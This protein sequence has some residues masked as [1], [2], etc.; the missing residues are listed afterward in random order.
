MRGSVKKKTRQFMGTDRLTGMP[1]LQETPAPVTTKIRFDW[2]S[3][4]ATISNNPEASLDPGWI[5]IVITAMISFLRCYGKK[6]GLSKIDMVCLHCEPHV[7]FQIN[8]D[9]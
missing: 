8:G 1:A 2:W 5:C 6:G 9:F 7:C 4:V 3:L